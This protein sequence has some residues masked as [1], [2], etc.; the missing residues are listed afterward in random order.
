MLVSLARKSPASLVYVIFPP[1]SS[2]CLCGRYDT[3]PISRTFWTGL[4]PPRNDNLIPTSVYVSNVSRSTKEGNFHIPGNTCWAHRHARPWT[5]KLEL[6]TSIAHCVPQAWSLVWKWTQL[7][8]MKWVGNCKT[9]STKIELCVLLESLRKTQSN[10]EWEAGLFRASCSQEVW[11]CG[12]PFVT[13]QAAKLP[14]FLLGYRCTLI[15]YRNG[16]GV[17]HR[18]FHCVSNHG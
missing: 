6:K 2:F 5:R 12:P 9:L 18:T 17:F 4:A 14:K 3:S 16:T 1:G 11:L 8:T 15:Y 7:A 10:W 13:L